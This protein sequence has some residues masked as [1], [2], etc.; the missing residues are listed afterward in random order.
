VPPSSRIVPTPDT[1]SGTPLAT[2]QDTDEVAPL[3]ALVARVDD[4]HSNTRFSAWGGIF[5]DDVVAA[6]MIDR[7]VHHPKI[8]GLK[9]DSYRRRDRDLALPSR[10][11]EL[12]ARRCWP[13]PLR[14]LD[15]PHGV[16]F[17]PALRGQLRPALT[18][19]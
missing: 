16:N 5:G 15:H 9:G 13:G 7:L 10:T 1:L 17:R 6:A 2:Q 11:T 12:S 4:H 19:A 14:R 18:H 3:I 8:V